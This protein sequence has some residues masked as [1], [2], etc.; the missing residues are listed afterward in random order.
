[1]AY[2]ACHAQRDIVSRLFDDTD[3]RLHVRHYW[4]PALHCAFT[5]Y[6]RYCRNNAPATSIAPEE[7]IFERM[8]SRPTY[9][10]LKR[11]IHFPA[12]YAH[13]SFI[14]WKFATL[15]SSR[16]LDF[17]S[18]IRRLNEHFISCYFIISITIAISRYNRTAKRYSKFQY[19]ELMSWWLQPILDTEHFPMTG[20]IPP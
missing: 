12:K 9:V 15:A 1:L 14:F 7:E 8:N 2:L 3:A 18:F 16:F 6:K 11:L 19:A 10:A 4:R 17:S 13:A 20:S 5:A